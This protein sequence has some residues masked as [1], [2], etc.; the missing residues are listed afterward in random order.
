MR[1]TLRIALATAVALVVTTAWFSQA[2]AQVA[3]GVVQPA[4]HT[5]TITGKVTQSNGAPVAGADVRISGLNAVLSTTTDQGGNFEFA[6]VPWGTYDITVTSSFGTA[7]RATV[8]VNA[9]LRVAIQYEAPSGLRTIAHVSTTAAG[10]HINITAASI[11]SLAPADYAFQGNTTWQQLLNQ[12]PGVV[13]G[14][15]LA[16]GDE[17]FANIPGSPEFP[18]EISIN[19]GLPYETSVTLDGMPIITTSIGGDTAG[20]GTDLAYLPMSIF[21]TADIVR[22]P[23]A[24]APSIVSSIGGSFVLH[25]PGEVTH[26]MFEYSVSNDYYGGVNSLVKAALRLTNRLSLV[27]TY[28]VNDS[29]GPYEGTIN[30]FVRPSAPLSIDGEHVWSCGPPSGTPCLDYASPSYFTPNCGCQ[31]DSTLL[32]CCEPLSTAW[33]QHVGAASLTYQIAPTVVAQVF[34]AG[35]SADM[36]VPAYE[37]PYLFEP[38][39]SYSGSI[40]PGLSRQPM[41]TGYET[42]STTASKLLEEKIT[43]FLG[44]GILRLGA[45]Q[46]NSFWNYGSPHYAGTY[47][48]GTYTVYGTAYVGGA[49]PGTLT[50]YNGTAE[51]LDYIPILDF[52]SWGWVNNRDL[53]ASYATQIGSSAN[54]GI[55]YV[56]SY[57]NSPSQGIFA[58][59]PYGNTSPA[60]SSTTNEWRFYAGNQFGDK[61]TADLSWYVASATYH[62]EN[63]SDPTGNTWQSTTYSYSAPRLGLTWRASPD[64]AIRGSVGG[65]FALP[66]LSYIVGLNLII[67]LGPYYYEI[68]ENLNLKPEESFGYDVGTDIRLQQDT[69]LSFD[70]Y[71]TDLYGQFYS[72]TATSGTYHGL[73]LLIHEYENLSHSRY[74]GLT[75]DLHHMPA[76]GLYWRLAFGLTRAYVVSVPP[77][78]FYVNDPLFGLTNANVVPGVNFNGSFVS[79]VPYSSGTAMLGY[80]W[81]RGSYFDLAPSYY[82]DDNAYF[83]PAFVE[84]DAHGGYAITRN[85]SILATLRNVTGV[86]DSDYEYLGDTTAAP[87]IHGVSPS[88][89]NS[90]VLFQLP[91][92]PRALIVTLN[93]KYE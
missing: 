47:P 37:F 64:I 59:S 43:A 8:L 82:G 18:V 34:Y 60:N 57:Y 19:G 41:D 62:V 53:L 35:S 67:P 70:V 9:D 93:Y 30:A 22:G 83:R 12:V 92:G 45:M 4:A 28:G 46:A 38:G 11:A 87:L 78:G 40:M 90:S 26:D 51:T 85:V 73:P 84:L 21:D 16:G 55:S 58:N 91:Y 33:D 14:G 63:P 79:A 71:R 1:V 13:V 54:A 3:P 25:P 61:F 66:P 7:S 77:T 86:Y 24:D 29:P 50:T 81:P 75:F 20:G 44:N 23:G 69:A 89:A 65:G 72:T 88:T 52:Y 42:N 39:S 56:T 5:A 49:S 27:M 15:G 10:A 6:A 17:A 80:R 48:D 2:N 36:Q 68:G 32:I 31:I 76:A 74:E